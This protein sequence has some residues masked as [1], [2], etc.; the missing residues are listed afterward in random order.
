MTDRIL[1]IEGEPA[2]R[3]ELASA[4]TQASFIVA[5]VPSYPEAL[6][7]LDEFNPDMVIMDE[8]LAGESGMRVC[9]QLHSSHGIPVILLGEDPGG[10]IWTRYSSH[11][12]PQ[13]PKPEERD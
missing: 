12:L 3:R 13:S 5:D 10:Q 1:I 11:S 9:S 4:L 6:A 7:K 2:L 8:V